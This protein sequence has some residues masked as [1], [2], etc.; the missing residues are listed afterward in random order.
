MKETQNCKCWIKTFDAL[1]LSFKK[2]GRDLSSAEFCLTSSD[3]FAVET[4][5]FYL[6]PEEV[7][8]LFFFFFFFFKAGSS[9]KQKKTPQNA[10]QVQWRALIAASQLGSVR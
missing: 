1:I 9:V 2:Q 6:K 4:P 7:R 5:A 8:R 3:A 10:E